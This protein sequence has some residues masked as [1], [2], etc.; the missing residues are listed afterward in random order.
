[1]MGRMTAKAAVGN[2]EWRIGRTGNSGSGGKSGVWAQQGLRVG[3]P[4]IR[5]T[6]RNDGNFLVALV[7]GEDNALTR[8]YNGTAERT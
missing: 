6:Q 1:M 8:S 4:K 7:F 2:R 5:A 3:N